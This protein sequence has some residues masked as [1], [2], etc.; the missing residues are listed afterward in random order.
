MLSPTSFRVEYK[1]P[2]STSVFQRN[3]RFNVDITLANSSA[4]SQNKGNSAN[5]TTH[6]NVDKSTI[7]CVTFTLLSGKLINN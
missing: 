6:P 2:G 7:Y 3:I 1:R 5:G 4:H